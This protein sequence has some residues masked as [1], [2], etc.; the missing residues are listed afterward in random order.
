[1]DGEQPTA[2]DAST[3]KSV[4]LLV[5]DEKR[6]LFVLEGALAKLGNGVEVITA[7]SAREG[8]EMMRDRGVDLVITDLIMPDIDG[9]EFTERIRSSDGDVIVVWMTAYG[10][11]SFREQAQ[12]LGVE[13]CVQKPLEIDQVR[14]IARE[15]LDHGAR[16]K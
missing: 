8:L 3:G 16:G 4:V 9:V 10:C 2:R 5:D 11:H 14:T 15:A 13:R 1:M 12:R 6:V 7:N